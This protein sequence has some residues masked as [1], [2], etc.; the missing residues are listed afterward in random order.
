VLRDC[1]NARHP[2]R[3]MHARYNDVRRRQ[4]RAD[5][6]NRFA[7]AKAV[8]GPPRVADIAGRT[9]QRLV[10]R[11]GRRRGIPD[12]QNHIIRDDLAAILEQYPERRTQTRA[13][14]ERY[15]SIYLPKL[16]NR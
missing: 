9:E 15:S 16:R 7:G 6:E 11:E 8:G 3:G 1:M 13:S 12:G 5:D 4:A 10:A 2:M 14:H